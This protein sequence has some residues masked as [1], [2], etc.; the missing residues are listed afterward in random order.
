M[1]VGTQSPS[2][3]PLTLTVLDADSQMEPGPFLHPPPAAPWLVPTPVITQA[4]TESLVC[5]WCRVNSVETGK[6]RQNSV[7]AECAADGVS[8]ELWGMKCPEHLKAR[9]HLVLNTSF[10]G[11]HL[12]FFRERERGPSNKRGIKCVLCS[13]SKQSS[14]KKSRKPVLCVPPLRLPMA[15]TWGSWRIVGREDR[16][17]KC[18][19]SMPA[20]SSAEMTDL[21]A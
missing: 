7:C 19:H 3:S 12:P 16:D 14:R 2:A 18:S 13:A 17:I 1:H 10:C 5:P 8:L 6:V 4:V 11:S 20:S 21:L 9:C 15:A